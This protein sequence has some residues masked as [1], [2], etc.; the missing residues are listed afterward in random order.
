MCRR[1]GFT[2]VEL[3][4]VIA[5]I[6]ILIAL[7]L[8]A[9][10]AAREAARRSQCSNNL[11]QFGLGFHNHHDAYRFFPSGGRGWQ[12]WSYKNGVPAVAPN[13][14]AGWG[15]QICPFIEQQPLWN[16]SGAKDFNGDGKIDD[17]EKFATAAGTPIQTFFC[18]SRRAPTV[19]SGNDEWVGGLPSGKNPKAMTDYA[20]NSYDT[21]DNWLGDEKAPWHN[22]GD[23]P[24]FRN[25]GGGLMQVSTFAAVKDGTTN[26]ILMGEKCLPPECYNDWCGDDNEGWTDGWDNDIMRHT[27][28]VPLSD[29]ARKGKGDGDLRFGSAHPAGLNVLLTDGSVR[30][31]SFSVNER[32]WRH[33]GHRDDGAPVQLD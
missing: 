12:Y 18:P 14:M 11:K 15:I 20:G 2:L 3:L 10:Q 8:P 33:L 4:V 32:L 5:I 29:I 24:I 31:F 30:M 1:K 13:Q 21:G 6:G 26:V 22:E 17:G 19:K 28:F 9:V 25:D 27:G 7:L 23:G 16:G